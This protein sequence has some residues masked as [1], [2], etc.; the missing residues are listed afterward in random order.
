MEH[1]VRGPIQIWTEIIF[2]A[3]EVLFQIKL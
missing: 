2:I 1:F 3:S